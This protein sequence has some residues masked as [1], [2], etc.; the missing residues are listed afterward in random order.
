MI[1]RAVRIVSTGMCLVMWGCGSAMAPAS[2]PTEQ[3]AVDGSD[4]GLSNLTSAEVESGY[5][6]SYPAR[7]MTANALEGTFDSPELF[8]GE[9]GYTDA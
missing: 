4:A 8:C 2:S 7:M 3:D 1:D 9:R 5:P 6:C